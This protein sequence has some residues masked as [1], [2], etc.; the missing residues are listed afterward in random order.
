MSAADRSVQAFSL[1][2]GE[3]CGEVPAVERNA[4]L[5]RLSSFDAPEMIEIRRPADLH[6]VGVTLVRSS[7]DTRR[8]N[9]SR[10]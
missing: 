10:R 6:E 5:P 9:P 3:R 4:V 2:A 7:N 1:N 8:V